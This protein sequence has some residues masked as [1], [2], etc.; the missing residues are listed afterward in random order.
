MKYRLTVSCV[1]LLVNLILL[2]VCHAGSDQVL[3]L[4]GRNLSKAVRE[5]DKSTSRKI[6][7]D[8]PEVNGNPRVL[9]FPKD[10]VV[11]RVYFRDK[12]IPMNLANSFKGWGRWVEA[13]GD[14]LVPQGAVVRFDPY[15]IAFKSGWALSTLKP[16]DIKTITFLWYE[17]ADSS[18][19][20]DI[21]RLTGL[22]QLFLSYCHSMETGL[23]HLVGLNKLK[24]LTLPG[25][26]RSSALGHLKELPSLETLSIGGQMMTDAKMVQ[27][28]KLSKLRG[29]SIVTN[30]VGP[31]LVH[32]QG[33]GSL[34]SLS[35]NGNRNNYIDRHLAHVAKLSQLE[36]LNLQD[37]WVGDEGLAN[38]KGLTNLKKLYLRG[39]WDSG[40]ITDAGMVHLKNLTSLQELELPNKELTD[41]GFGHLAQMDSLTK[42]DITTEMTDKTMAKLPGMKSLKDLSIYSK[43]ITEAGMAE[44]ANCSS[45]RSLS[46]YKCSGTDAG[47]SRVAKIKSLTRLTIVGIRLSGERLDVLKDLP[48]LT[49]LSF[50]GTDI[51]QP[52]I[53]NIAGLKGI[54]RLSLSLPNSTSFGDK[55]L[56]TLSAMSSLKFLRVS[57]PEA[58]DSFITDQGL[59][60]ISTLT[61]IEHLLLGVNCENVTDAGLK[62]LEALTSLKDLNLPNSRIT[63]AG[64][65][66]LQKKIPGVTIDAG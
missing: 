8:T 41:E 57:H 16:D 40:R 22:E 33:L 51:G 10:Y 23:K 7:A 54:T 66:R 46:L 61:G 25:Q 37:T 47:L 31:G 26:F 35:L 9:H 44:L 65:E 17:D 19:L 11:G 24:H 15:K 42:V 62:H 32:L 28:G 4:S 21:G 55:D 43:K 29:L 20:K 50:T 27:I 60:Y 36:S 59:A 45:L 14:I 3:S 18:V 49:S 63:R 5:T 53:T 34:R 6:D 58:E 38:L 39:K 56:A 12:D 1:G 52:G 2:P 64:V 30:E 13:T 48:N